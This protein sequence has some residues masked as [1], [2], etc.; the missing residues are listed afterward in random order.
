M[1]Y[2]SGF[3]SIN[4]GENG[5]LAAFFLRTYLLF[6][7]IEGGYMASSI[8]PTKIHQVLFVYLTQWSN[9]RSIFF[10]GVWF[11]RESGSALWF[12]RGGGWS[13]TQKKGQ[14]NMADPF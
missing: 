2:D 8:I 3:L 9:S 5:W 13:G 10:Q 11:E 7:P 1:K 4:L 6:H 14:P 12:A